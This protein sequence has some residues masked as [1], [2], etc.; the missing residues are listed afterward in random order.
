MVVRITF[1]SQSWRPHAEQ[2]RA[3]LEP[4]VA[5][6]V[7]ELAVFEVQEH[8]FV[9]TRLVRRD[10]TLVWSDW[11]AEDLGDGQ[12]AYSRVFRSADLSAQDIVA[13]L[14]AQLAAPRATD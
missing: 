12:T 14:R 7:S 13:S 11:S 1:L 3:K 5:S 2:L 8:P 10:R 4:L 6:D 9:E